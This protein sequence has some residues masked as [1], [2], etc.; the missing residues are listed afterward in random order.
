[1]Q[2]S[3][4]SSFATNK[5]NYELSYYIPRIHVSVT[6][7]DIRYILMNISCEPL[8]LLPFPSRIDIIEIP[9]NKHFKSAFVYHDCN[10]KDE[11]QI[12]KY[13]ENII[14]TSASNQSNLKIN[15]GVLTPSNPNAY[16]IILPNQNK[17]TKYAKLMT[18]EL[19]EVGNEVTT[20]LYILAYSHVDIPNNIDLSFEDKP[21]LNL[22]S[23]ENENLIAEKLQNALKTKQNLEQLAIYNHL[24]LPKD[25]TILYKFDKE[26]DVI[27]TY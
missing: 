7:S 6:E 8:S 17:L 22:N 14:K 12:G 3:S 27:L 20:L 23:Q 19:K 25:L 13:I 15:C 11:I 9:N 1:M 16:W 24:I 4:S 26:N 18:D 5:E 2:D 21:V 10:N